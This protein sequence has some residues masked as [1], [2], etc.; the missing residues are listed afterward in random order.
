MIQ[1]SEV[2]DYLKARV[3]GITIITD[4]ICGFPTETSEDFQVCSI[5]LRKFF[6]LNFQ[7]M[8]RLCKIIISCQFV[9]PIIIH[10]P[11]DRFASNFVWKLGRTAGIFLIWLLDSK[12]SGSTFQGKKAKT[13]IY[14]Q[15][16]V[17]GGRNLANTEFPS[18]FFNLIFKKI[19]KFSTVL[20]KSIL[21]NILN[22][23]LDKNEN[24]PFYFFIIIQETMDLVKKYRFPSLFINQFF[25][26]YCIFYMIF[27]VASRGFISCIEEINNKYILVSLT[28]SLFM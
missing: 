5:F 16:R 12:L 15:A 11:L 23:L 7:L 4:I 24:I 20:T 8:F 27:N 6:N 21:K 22:I 14:D 28:L 3:P 26:R 25:P 2:V 1:F 18:Y 17:N 10:E 19:T 9:C 13:V